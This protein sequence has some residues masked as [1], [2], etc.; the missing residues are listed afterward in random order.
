MQNIN[1][2]TDPHYRYKMQPISATIAGKGNGIFTIFNNLNDI[3]KHLNH[4]TTILLKF[5]SIYF[6]SMANDDKMTITG[7]HKNDDLQKAL[8]IYIN[9]FIICPSCDVPETIPALIGSKKDINIELK[10]SAC[11]KTSAVVCNNKIEEKGL[12][13]IIKYLQKNTW[14]ISH[15]GTMVTSSKIDKTYEE[16][17]E[18]PFF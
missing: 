4:P 6:G 8:Q 12:D 15:K 14:T 1:G 18:N 2:K 5:I 7:G 11:G 16:D 13:L 9:R 3:A 17:I 10:C